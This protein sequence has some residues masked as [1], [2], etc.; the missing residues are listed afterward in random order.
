[1]LTHSTQELDDIMSKG[2]K[3]CEEKG[4]CWPLGE[5]GVKGRREGTRERG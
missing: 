1:M 4:Y 5:R 2:M 3:W